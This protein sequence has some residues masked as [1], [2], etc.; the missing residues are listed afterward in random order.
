MENLKE[1]KFNINK[2]IK[3]LDFTIYTLEKKYPPTYLSSLKESIEK[4]EHKLQNHIKTLQE[5]QQE[6]NDIIRFLNEHK[7]N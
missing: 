5:K 1:Q 4:E 7:N 2:E 6:L 3:N